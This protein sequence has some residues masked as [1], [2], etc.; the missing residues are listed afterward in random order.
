MSAV[1]RTCIVSIGVHGVITTSEIHGQ[2]YVDFVKFTDD[3]DINIRKVSFAPIGKTCKKADYNNEFSKLSM[4]TLEKVGV[5]VNNFDE[6]EN[7]V[8]DIVLPT[9][10]PQRRAGFE[11]MYEGMPIFLNKTYG[12]EFAPISPAYKIMVDVKDILDNGEVKNRA[13]FNLLDLSDLL[14]WIAFKNN[15]AQQYTE[16]K[17]TNEQ[18]YNQKIQQDAQLMLN[19]FVPEFSVSTGIINGRRYHLLSKITFDQICKILINL[20][21]FK[22]IFF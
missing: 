21:G 16:L 8:R 15:I 17:N 12:V 9:L 13:P 1:Q 14:G 22:N 4:E 6:I 18:L 2:K 20:L 11:I 5:D 19:E 10:A 7:Y 3:L